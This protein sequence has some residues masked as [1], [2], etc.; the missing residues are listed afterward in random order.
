MIVV[1]AVQSLHHFRL[2]V[3]P[4]MQQAWLF[5][6]TV[7]QSLLTFMSI[8][9][10]MLSNHLILCLPILLL[11]SVFPSIRIFTNESALHNRW[12]KYSVS[13]SVLL[14]NIQGWFPLGFTDTFRPGGVHLLVSCLFAFSHC[15]WGSGSNTGAGCHLLLLWT[16]FCQNSSLWPIHLGWLCMEWLIASLSY[17]SPFTAKVMIQEGEKTLISGSKD[18]YKA[19]IWQ[20]TSI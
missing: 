12:P 6:S 4:W 14:V 15:S 11:L 2:F 17:V 8:E 1:V 19:Y 20:R 13:E 5:C 3:A 7:S 9:S 18:I 10:V 16:T